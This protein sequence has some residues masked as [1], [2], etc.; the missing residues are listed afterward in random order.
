VLLN[1]LFCLEI[2]LSQVN[3]PALPT[4][5]NSITNELAA[6]N[7][8]DPVPMKILRTA[9]FS[10]TLLFAVGAFAWQYPSGG[11]TTQPPQQQPSQPSQTQP[12][13]TQPGQPQQ[14]QGSA[15]PGAHNIDDQVQTL[16]QELSLTPDQQTKV[17]TAL[18]DQHTQA[19]QV[20]QDSSLP[21]EDKIQKIH[22]IR[23][24]TI[25]KVRATLTS[26]D[27]KQK[28]DQM[29]Q[30]QDNR[31]HQQQPPSQQSPSQQP[32]SQQPPSQQPPKH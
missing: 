26:D 32:P 3:W 15:Q 17:K 5:K 30:A 7:E 4:L 16:T 6:P 12:S 22:A 14:P 28:F 31:M 2:F 23:E 19:M 11:Q 9:L 29:L 8:G 27:Q 21:R 24:N 25:A 18:E 13:Q 20:I 10:S 1:H